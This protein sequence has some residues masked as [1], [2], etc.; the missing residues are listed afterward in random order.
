MTHLF[1][2]LAHSV[3]GNVITI[4]ALELAAAIIGFIIAWLYARSLYSPVIKGL[5]TDKTNLNNQIAKLKDEYSSINEKVNKLTEKISKLEEE[6]TAKDNEIKILSAEP[7]YP[8]TE[9]VQTETDTVNSLTDSGHIGKYVIGKA[10][11]GEH[12]FN[13]KATN[14]QVIL[15][16][17]MFPSMA[18]CL[19][20][21]ESVREICSDDNNFERKKS[22]NNKPYFNLKASD[23]HILGKSEMYE[24]IANMEKGISSV[25]K[26]GGSN[27]IIEE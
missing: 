15:T 8:G 19:K 9:P 25:K 21:I 4:V 2:Q 16:S 14:G 24:A 26:N 27:I 11:S 7:V 23:G 17:G 1:V 12:Y 5:E 6:V 20:G 18:D 3:T 22:S 13:L 10:K